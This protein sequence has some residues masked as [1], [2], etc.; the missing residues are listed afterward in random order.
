MR[1]LPVTTEGIR[2]K[3]LSYTLVGIALALLGVAAIAAPAFTG[4]AVQHV[5]GWL[6]LL[7]GL[8]TAVTTWFSKREGWKAWLALGSAIAAIVG[9]GLLL[10]SPIG[11]QEMLSSILVAFFFAS[12]AAKV[13]IALLQR[14][15]IPRLWPWLLASG[16]IDIAMA[17]A[18]LLRWPFGTD[19]FLGMM[20]GISFLGT[21]LIVMLIA[22]SGE[23]RA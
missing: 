12:G 8:F 21:G 20:T 7:A 22:T 17:F 23:E 13:G 9:G 18:V 14:A 19:W 16:A 2:G 11:G 6:L 1:A 15:T 4:E 5:V 3:R 10:W